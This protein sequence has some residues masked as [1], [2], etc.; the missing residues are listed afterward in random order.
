MVGPGRNVELK[1]R[2]PDP[3][4]SLAL[5]RSLGAKE[6]G[7]L[8]QRD[9]Y[10]RVPHGRLKLREEGA[11][12]ELIGYE[13]P[14]L[15]AQRESSYRRVPVDD[16][17]ALKAAL[18]AALG[19]EATVVKERRLFAWEGVRIHLDRVKGLGDF[20]EFEAVIGAALDPGSAGR[21]VEQ[22]RRAFGIGEDRLIGQSYCDLALA[23]APA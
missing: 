9:T 2:D 15:A 4:G 14:D 5:C 7:V 22:L 23:A 12:A 17:E 20:V 21:R 16:P 19:V 6:R 13:R 10:F 3:A 1:A 18:A 8:A 11:A